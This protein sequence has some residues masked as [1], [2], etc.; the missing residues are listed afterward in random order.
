MMERMKGSSL[1]SEGPFYMVSFGN[2]D[3]I[4]VPG[5]IISP[6]KQAAGKHGEETREKVIVTALIAALLA[7]L[8][9]IG[10]LV[11][12]RTARGSRSFVDAQWVFEQEA[13]Q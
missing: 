9:F 3:M 1:S 8:V 13:L 10:A 4:R 12:E 6:E 11:Q 2:S 7:A 5:S